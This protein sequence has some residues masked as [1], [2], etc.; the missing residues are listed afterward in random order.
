MLNFK[1]NTLLICNLLNKKLEQ[2]VLKEIKLKDQLKELTFTHIN[3]RI[4][5]LSIVDIE[6][7]K[8]QVNL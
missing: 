5:E 6:H 4:K 3:H 8:F 2:Q 7:G 1:K